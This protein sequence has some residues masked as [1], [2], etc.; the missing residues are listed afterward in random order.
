VLASDDVAEAISA[1]MERRAPK[2]TGG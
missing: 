1:F 2:F